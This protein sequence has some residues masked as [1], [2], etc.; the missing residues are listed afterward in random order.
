MVNQGYNTNVKLKRITTRSVL[1]N[2]LKNSNRE[3]SVKSYQVNSVSDSD[4]LINI[5]RQLIDND[6]NKNNND[7]AILIPLKSNPNFNQRN[8]C[9][10]NL[11]DKKN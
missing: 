11:H 4:Q 2:N 8:S 5:T 6:N 9:I 7:N 10:T 1:T 3:D